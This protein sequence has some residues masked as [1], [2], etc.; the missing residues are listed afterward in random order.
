MQETA[1]ALKCL[2]CGT[3]LININIINTKQYLDVIVTFYVKTT[4]RIELKL[5]IDV[6]LEQE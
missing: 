2:S 6:V 1:G 3:C 5:C 4:G